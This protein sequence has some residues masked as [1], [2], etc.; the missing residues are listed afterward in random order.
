MSKY[1]LKDIKFSENQT[2]KD[3]NIFSPFVYYVFF[4]ILEFYCSW[5]MPLIIEK[6]R[7]KK[8]FSLPFFFQKRKKK[9][10]KAKNPKHTLILLSL[11][12]RVSSWKT[13]SRFQQPPFFSYW[14][15]NR[16]E[17]ASCYDCSEQVIWP[18]ALPVAL[19][20]Q[21]KQNDGSVESLDLKAGSVSLSKEGCPECELQKDRDHTHG[22]PVPDVTTHGL[23]V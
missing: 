22:I 4:I 16:V 15:S 20:R 7:R 21:R 1:Y 18:L 3:H 19:H 13:P 5:W 17:S 12:S 11:V 8:K 2:A 9:L 14:I 10:H 6:G 23:F